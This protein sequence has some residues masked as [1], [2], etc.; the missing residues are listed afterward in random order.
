MPRVLLRVGAWCGPC[1]V[2]CLVV[3][4]SMCMQAHRQQTTCPMRLAGAVASPLRPTARPAWPCSRVCCAC[5][6][7]WRPAPAATPL[8][9]DAPCRACPPHA[10]PHPLC[11]ALGR[12]APSGSALQLPRTPARCSAGAASVPAERLLSPQPLTKSNCPAM[13]RQESA[14][15]CSFFNVLSGTGDAQAV[16]GAPPLRAA[17]GVTRRRWSARARISGARNHKGSKAKI[18]RT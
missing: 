13:A 4:R 10:A 15:M 17:V 5:L 14:G 11:C 3:W 1:R 12:P 18:A 2:M 7:A 8:A 9:E 6:E 16:S